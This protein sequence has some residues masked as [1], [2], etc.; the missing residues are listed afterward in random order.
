M[1]ELIYHTAIIT[2]ILLFIV[3]LSAGFIDTLAGGGGMITV[4]A[5]LISG[6]PPDAA[7]ATNKLQGSFGTLSA[8]LYFIKTGHLNLKKTGAGIISCALGAAFGTISVQLLPNQYLITI[9]PILLLSVAILFIFLPQLGAIEQEARL[10]PRHFILSA[11]LP[12]AFYDGFLG[13][14]TG[15]FFMLALIA[16]QGKTLQNATIEAKIYNATTNLISL[17]VFML[18]GKIVWL[19]GLT[20]AFGQILGARLASRLILNKGNRL[21]RPMVILISILLSIYLIL[22]NWLHIF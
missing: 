14:G 17:L 19:I 13:P 5:L 8:S 2:L 1:H 7:L 6:L 20:M 22:R 9:L 3:G 15:S 18:S 10:K 4:P 21:I 11:L 12:I 16:L